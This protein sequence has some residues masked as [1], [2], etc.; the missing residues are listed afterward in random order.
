M[1]VFTPKVKMLT[2][3]NHAKLLT[4]SAIHY[5]TQF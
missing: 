4:L 3:C 1:I 5:Q 2:L